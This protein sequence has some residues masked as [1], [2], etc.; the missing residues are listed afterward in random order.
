MDIG[1]IGLEIVDLIHLAKVRVSWR[2][3]LNTAMKLR[4]P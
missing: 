1:K 3:L 4:A 2:A